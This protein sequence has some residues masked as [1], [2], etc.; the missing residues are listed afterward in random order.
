M[1]NCLKC[2]YKTVSRTAMRL[3]VKEYHRVKCWKHEKSNMGDNSTPY[4]SRVSECYEV[5][6]E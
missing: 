3:H 2:G 5:T 6:E 4:R 1:Y